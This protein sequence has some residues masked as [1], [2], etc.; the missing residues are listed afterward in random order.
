[1]R[2]KNNNLPPPEPKE[3]RFN[4]SE[5]VELLTFLIA[6]MGGMSRNSVK[7]LLSHR[8]VMVNEVISTQ[9]NFALK[10]ND[11]DYQCF[12]LLQIRFSNK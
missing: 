11:K 9:F 12:I 10:P 2:K 4:V 6:K 5:H 3:T 1:M 8:Q 7:S